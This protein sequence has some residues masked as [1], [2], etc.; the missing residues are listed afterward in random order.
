MVGGRSNVGK[1]ER[2]RRRARNARKAEHPGPPESGGHREDPENPDTAAAPT[3]DALIGGAVYALACGDTGAFQRCADQLTARSPDG[4]SD[5][6]GPALF[7]RLIE[8][9]GSAWERGWQPDEVVRQVRRR[10]TEQIG[11]AH[12]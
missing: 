3:V 7:T 1:A 2:A 11:R 6:A 9:V 4:G 5:D 10:R 12:V 8:A